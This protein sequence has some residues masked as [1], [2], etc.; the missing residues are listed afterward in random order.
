MKNHS[1]E[2]YRYLAK[3]EPSKE[4]RILPQLEERINFARAPQN[5]AQSYEHYSNLLH[6]ATERHIEIIS[7]INEYLIHTLMN[8]GE[9]EK[10]LKTVYQEVQSAFS[11]SKRAAIST[12]EAYGR[13]SKLEMDEEMDFYHRPEMLT[14]IET[15]AQ[16]MLTFLSIPTLKSLL[17]LKELENSMK[18]IC[19]QL[20]KVLQYNDPLNEKPYSSFAIELEDITREAALNINSHLTRIA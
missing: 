14:T 20:F 7:P 11:V 3:W 18:E 16:A 5:E 19:S 6:N 13:V 15:R 17:R 10:T 12:I 8:F 9:D 4:E 1:A 2:A